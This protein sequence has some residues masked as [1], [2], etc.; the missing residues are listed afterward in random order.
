MRK[1]TADGADPGAPA[2]IW[3]VLQP[4]DKEDVTAARAPANSASRLGRPENVILRKDGLRDPLRSH[5]AGKAW[6]TLP[7]RRNRAPGNGRL[8]V[9]LGPGTVP[10]PGNVQIGCPAGSTSNSSVPLR[11]PGEESYGSL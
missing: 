5:P 6:D 3:A 11:W 7:R 9:D 8:R 2:A 10:D 4:C 1:D